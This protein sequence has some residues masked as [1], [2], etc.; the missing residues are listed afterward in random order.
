MNCRGQAQAVVVCQPEIQ[1]DDVRL[2]FPDLLEG[3]V[4]I[5]GC[6]QDLETGLGV[7]HRREPLAQQPVVVD[8]HQRDGSLQQVGPNVPNLVRLELRCPRHGATA[9]VRRDDS[10]G[11]SR[12]PLV[13]GGGCLG[14]NTWKKLAVAHRYPS[15]RAPSPW[16]R[17]ESRQ[18]WHKEYT[19]A[20]YADRADTVNTR[21]R[22]E[23]DARTAR[24]GG[25]AL[26]LVGS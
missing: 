19:A 22:A 12:C 18:P 11:L 2:G 25:L 5:R 8:E 24:P 3:L 26:W 17:L 15:T 23:A 1:E 14:E 20:K 21:V 9:V 4:D 10:E 16:C 13:W 7:D 6:R